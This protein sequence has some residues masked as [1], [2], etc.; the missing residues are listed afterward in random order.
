MFKKTLGLSLLLACGIHNAGAREASLTLEVPGMSVAEYHRPYIAAWLMDGKR[1]VTNLTLW[2]QVDDR[3]EGEKWL[4]DLR[5]WWRRSGRSLDMPVDGFTGATQ[6]QGTHRVDLQ[7][8]LAE[9]PPGDY[10][11]YVEAARE[12]G[13]RELLRLPF[14]WTAT[15]PVSVSA[16]GDSELGEVSLQ[17]TP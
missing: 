4:K 13:G 3:R 6:P 11:L 1:Q 12:V 8:Q 10:T 9:L 2:Y 17:I 15:G 7:G 14:S 5:Q 16:A